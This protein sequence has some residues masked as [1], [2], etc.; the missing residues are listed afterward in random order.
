MN[1]Y[2]ITVED[3]IYC[4][5]TIIV[6]ADNAAAATLIAK[7]KAMNGNVEMHPMENGEDNPHVY[8]VSDLDGEEIATLGDGFGTSSN[9]GCLTEHL[10]GILARE[11]IDKY[12]FDDEDLHY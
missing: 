10:E 5:G 11:G 4:S 9:D 7:K 12:D 3:R 8:K 6:E 2:A 1:T